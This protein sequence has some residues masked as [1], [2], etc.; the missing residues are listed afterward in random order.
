MLRMDCA[1][2]WKERYDL[3]IKALL[4]GS[5]FPTRA[6]A[7]PE[8]RR[9]TMVEIGGESASREVH[10]L[11]GLAA[12]ESN[13]GVRILYACE[14][15]S[16]A[17][18]FASRDS[19]W[20]VRFLYVHPPAW[21]VSVAERRDV[22]EL[23]IEA[24]LDI[25]GWELRKA[26]RLLRKGNPAIQEWLHSPIVYRS[27]PGFLERVRTLAGE[28]YAPSAALYHYLHMA[29]GNHREYLHGQEVRLKKYL[30]VL[31]PVL[32]CLWIER[33]LGQPPVAF[34]ELMEALIPE[35]ALRVAILG[36]LERKASGDELD[37]GSAIPELDDFLTRELVRLQAGIAIPP[38]PGIDVA[39]LDA[40]LWDCVMPGPALVDRPR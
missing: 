12:I 30:Y 14:S 36:L 17:W 39:R 3:A 40:L 19:D 5:L 10:I 9:L 32:A 16:R 18:G 28:A 11:R 7:Y 2:S 31:R 27:A 23:P 33:G 6:Q 37:R 22:I 15:G 13:H 38:A 29:R 8:P 24:D 20:D 4:D 21:Y 26:L 35:G 34:A 25:S 1:S